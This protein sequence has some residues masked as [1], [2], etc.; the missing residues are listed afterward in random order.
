MF[1]DSLSSHEDE[2]KQW[3]DGAAPEDHLLPKEFIEKVQKIAEA[4]RKADIKKEV[5]AK[6]A[7]EEG[8]PGE[9]KEE[10]SLN[11]IS[12]TDSI[13]YEDNSDDNSVKSME[14]NQ[15]N[16]RTNS[17]EVVVEEEGLTKFE[18][19][20]IL[21][22]LRPD[23][24]INGIKRFIL[25][26]FKPNEHFIQS[27]TPDLCKVLMQSSA[28]S[29]IVF[30]LSPGAD[31]ISEVE[32]LAKQHGFSGNK[33][34]YLSLGQNMEAEAE[35]L[36]DNSSNRGHWV[37]LQNC[38]L[39]PG[40]LG[41]LEK[42]LEKM[43]KP[44]ED[45]RLWLTTKP[46][47]AF[48]I[49]I[50]QKAM[51]I[52]TEP[53]DGLRQNIKAL[54]AKMSDDNLSECKHPNFKALN[55]V[56]MFFHAV[57]LDRKKFGKIGFNIG[58]DF[59]ES[60]FRIS[61]RLL[62]LYLTKSISNNEPEM[63]WDSLKYLIGDA[64]YGGRVTDEFD[65]RVLKTYLDEY[66]GDFLFDKNNRFLFAHT[67]NYSYDLPEFQNI[68]Q[69]NMSSDRL[70]IF[71]EPIIFGLHA[72]AEITYF[73]N[74]AKAMWSNLLKMT[75]LSEGAGGG[76]FESG[77]ISQI[78][79]EISEMIPLPFDI[80]EMKANS[81]PNPS[82][83][84][85]VLLQEVERF[86][87][88]IE[89]MS[90]SLNDLIRAL[91]GEIAM[92]SE[93][94]EFISNLM[95]GFLPS[96]WTSLC[97]QTNKTLASW[98]SHFKRR[99]LQYHDW[100]NK[101]EPTVIW[102]SGLHIPESYLTAIIQIC[103]RKNKWALDKVKLR[104]RLTKFKSNKE[105]TEKLEFGCYVDGLFMEGASWCEDKGHIIRQS[106]K[107]LMKTLPLMEIVPVETRKLK[108]KNIIKVPVY[109]TQSRGDAT[110]QGLVFNADLT[111][112]EHESHWILQGVAIVLNKD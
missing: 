80:A 27:P 97:P 91:S 64:M 96:K 4:K 11:N 55:Y 57:L 14:I 52:V 105:V 62:S 39:L 89:A 15:E 58:Y 30:I 83:T 93:I 1:A 78:A 90:R 12:I 23:R 53:P 5:D 45:F 19:L 95:N 50:L 26:F 42:I 8:E 56:I 88:L 33:F 111:I 3:A 94:E 82:S 79:N 32:T 35:E 21:K 86:N 99:Y 84:H 87:L 106:P 48:P 92:N 51:K 43:D 6:K 41:N 68:E 104:T 103:C 61:S 49:G 100:A 17:K 74:A 108:T 13:S 46:S 76:N 71:D 18:L 40:W 65:E 47:K 69:L 75:S 102:L 85:I 10:V 25:D 60:D 2:W 110:G 81:P 70:P 72:N 34:K 67:D 38:D 98:M 20:M 77:H 54:S 59:N 107:E 16:E 109:M 7:D 66:M 112:F 37:M 31:P 9:T 44:H 63:P 73:T 36:I 101:G 24:V 22:I 28:F 29:P